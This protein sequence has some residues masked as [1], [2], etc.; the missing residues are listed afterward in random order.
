LQIAEELLAVVAEWETSDVSDPGYE[1]L[2]DKAIAQLVRGR[3]KKK[4][5][6]MTMKSK[7]YHI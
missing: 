2:T 4:M 5:N 6:Q 7:G 1:Q 3:I